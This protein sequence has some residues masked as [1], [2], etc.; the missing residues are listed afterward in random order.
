MLILGTLMLLG[1]KHA[2]RYPWGQLVSVA[3]DP[4]VIAGLAMM[5][6]TLYRHNQRDEIA[7]YGATEMIW[8][9][10]ATTLIWYWIHNVTDERIAARVLSGDL[11]VD[12]VRPL[13]VIVWELGHAASARVGGIVLEFLPALALYSLWFRPTFLTPASMLRFVVAASLAFLLFFSLNFLIGLSGL[14]VYG[15]NAILGLKHLLV[16]ACAGAFVPLEFLPHSVQH[17]LHWLPFPYIFYW[18]VQ[19]FLGRG[20]AGTW[21]GWFH[22]EAIAASWLVALLVLCRLLWRRAVRRYAGAGG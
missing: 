9:F 4:I 16:T 5:F 19:T 6:T 15:P 11:T 10:A 3:I 21:S 14:Y 20:E 12:L 22:R 8:Y 18:P 17:V 7:G 1:G 13:P 2:Y